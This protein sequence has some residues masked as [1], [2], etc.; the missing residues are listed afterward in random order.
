MKGVYLKRLVW[1]QP[2]GLS[3]PC[4]RLSET[5]CHTHRFGLYPVGRRNRGRLISKTVT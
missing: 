2:V 3:S 4:V 1:G 5:A